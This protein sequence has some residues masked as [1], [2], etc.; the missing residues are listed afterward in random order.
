V[1]RQRQLMRC[2]LKPAVIN[3]LPI[4]IKDYPITGSHICLIQV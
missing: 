4:Y 1:P 3:K 2:G